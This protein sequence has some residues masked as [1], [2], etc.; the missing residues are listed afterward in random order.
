[1]AFRRLAAAA[2]RPAALR[3]AAAAAAASLAAG[4]AACLSLSEWASQPP[5]HAAAAAA[6]SR[7][8]RHEAWARADL[9]LS[10]EG[11]EGHAIFETLGARTNAIPAYRV[12]ARRDGGGVAAVACL[13]AGCDGHR[14]V[15]HGGVTALLLDNT[16]GWANAV[17]V[18]AEA[19]RLER[20]LEGKGEGGEGGGGSAARFGFTANLLVNYRAPLARGSAVEVVCRVERVEGRKRYLVGEMRNLETGELVA[21][22]TSLFV[23]PAPRRDAARRGGGRDE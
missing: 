12:Y 18:L 4:G 3:T 16:L 1:M 13:G 6:I 20:V 7:Y 5:P 14:D 10:P 17:A 23:I 11:G 22:C 9:T 15:V 19:G 21:D 8:E 2:F